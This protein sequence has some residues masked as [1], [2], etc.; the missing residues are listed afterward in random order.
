MT[1]NSTIEEA[2]RGAFGRRKTH[3]LTNQGFHMTSSTFDTKKS[4]NGKPRGL[5]RLNAGN[6]HL[7]LGRTA[8]LGTLMPSSIFGGDLN[9]DIQR[10]QIVLTCDAPEFSGLVYRLLLTAK[11]GVVRVTLPDGSNMAA[12][13]YENNREG[14]WAW[15]DPHSEAGEGFL[16][17]CDLHKNMHIT[18]LCGDDGEH[19]VC[20][21]LTN[22]KRS[23]NRVPCAARSDVIGVRGLAARPYSVG[24]AI[25]QGS[26][27]S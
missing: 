2:S 4:T 18:F 20:Q 7:N 8:V 1:Y 13:A 14:L 19:S 12:I 26:S 6:L 21:P 16:R 23:I 10:P 17:D 5:Q 9:W 24:S 11:V 27:A 25:F 3:S 15:F 22:C